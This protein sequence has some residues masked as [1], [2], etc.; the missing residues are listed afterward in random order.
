MRN[1]HN[2]S[3]IEKEIKMNVQAIQLGQTA[4]LAR[5]NFG[6]MEDIVVIADSS[7]SINMIVRVKLI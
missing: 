1:L 3:R 4:S 6:D 7:I 5:S 2:Y